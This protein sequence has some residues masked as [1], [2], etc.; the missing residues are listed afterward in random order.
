MMN[1]KNW[2]QCF[3]TSAS[4]AIAVG[5]SACL[6]G[7]LPAQEHD[8]GEVFQIQTLPA[9][10]ADIQDPLESTFKEAF[11][12][13]LRQPVQPLSSDRSEASPQDADL[14]ESPPL[15][16]P[17]AKKIDKTWLRRDIRSLRVNIREEA[18]VAPQDRSAELDY[19]LGFWSDQFDQ[20][21]VFRWVAPDIYYAQLYF[22]DVAL[23]RYGQTAGPYRQFV[24]SGV[25]FFR[26]VAMLPNK[27]CND[28]PRTLDYP[29][30]FCRPGSAAPLTQT[31]HYRPIH[32]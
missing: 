11:P 3:V 13:P 7:S 14:K 23:E 18:T 9:V 16:L 26:S 32:R 4:M 1:I 5:G 30:G 20:P 12:Q 22:E 27:V 15:E 6:A 28:T 25:H 31:R 19:G 2:R 8:R 21:C 10:R 24:R 17:A 29:L